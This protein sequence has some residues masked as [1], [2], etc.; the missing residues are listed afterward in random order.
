MSWF[1]KKS[2]QGSP[3]VPIDDSKP[4]EPE[5]LKVY[6]TQ[7]ISGQYTFR[8]TKIE[9]QRSREEYNIEI[10]L[11]LDL[12]TVQTPVLPIKLGVWQKIG[13]V[14]LGDDGFYDGVCFYPEQYELRRSGNIIGPI[15]EACEYLKDQIGK[16][17]IELNGWEHV[18]PYYSHGVRN[19]DTA[20][21]H[22]CYTFVDPEKFKMMKSN[23]L[24]TYSH[25]KYKDGYRF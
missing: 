23:E 6:I 24:K 8:G 25:S 3:E 21:K 5:L 19:D 1:K 2:E 15:K 20:E 16:S 13:S 9:S 22:F 12:R 11:R 7:G 18:N 17:I 14:T 4:T 10:L